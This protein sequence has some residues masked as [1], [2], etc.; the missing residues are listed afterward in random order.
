MLIGFGRFTVI[1]LLGPALMLTACASSGKPTPRKPVQPPATA[2]TPC[3]LP[4]LPD[5]LNEAEAIEAMIKH[6]AEIR[7]C[8]AKRAAL[9]AGWP[10]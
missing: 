9:V 1:A 7:R 8:E 2:L 5:T 10:Q 4:T 6:R 3:A